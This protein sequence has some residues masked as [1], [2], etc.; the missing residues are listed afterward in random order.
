MAGE[1][2][3]FT[4]FCEGC[5][6]LRLTEA[7]QDNYF[8]VHKFRPNHRCAKFNAN[9]LHLGAHPRLLRAGVCLDNNGYEE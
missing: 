3:D 9:V 8:E 6:H 1:H 7:E 5:K 4:K 2:V